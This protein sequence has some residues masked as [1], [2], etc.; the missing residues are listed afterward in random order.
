MEIVKALIQFLIDHWENISGYAS[1]IILG[2]L[3]RWADKKGIKNAVSAQVNG[4]TAIPE[5]LK[6][7]IIQKIIEQV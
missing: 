6:Y 2:L 7:S 3:K 5:D 1:V 4:S